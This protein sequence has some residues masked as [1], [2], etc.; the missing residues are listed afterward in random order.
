MGI[1]E[2]LVLV[3]I[4]G[5]IYAIRMIISENK[6]RKKADQDLKRFEE[7]HPRKQ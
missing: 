7:E 1:I 4:A 6:R 5:V 3:A 2:I